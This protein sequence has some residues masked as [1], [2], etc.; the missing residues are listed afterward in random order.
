MFFLDRLLNQKNSS[1]QTICSYRDT[2]KLLLNF[3][4]SKKKKQ[5]SL[6][7][8]LDFNASVIVDFLEHL[9]IERNNS[10]NSRNSR[11]SAIRS[12][13]NMLHLWCQNIMKIFKPFLQSP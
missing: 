12:F 11:L 3:I 7:T 13:L 9:E 5:P 6:L 8:F 10:I 4:C 1:P 2:F